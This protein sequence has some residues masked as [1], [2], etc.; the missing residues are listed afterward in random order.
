MFSIPGKIKN[1][2]LP[3]V[4]NQEAYSKLSSTITSNDKDDKN[5]QQLFSFRNPEAGNKITFGKLQVYPKSY[6]DT[7]TNDIAF[8]SLYPPAGDG[9]NIVINTLLKYIPGIQIREFLPDTK[10]DQTINLFQQL[11]KVA[12]VA[13]QNFTNSSKAAIDESK[14]QENSD[15]TQLAFNTGSGSIFDKIQKIS[16]TVIDYLT[17]EKGNMFNN[18]SSLTDFTKSNTYS[19]KYQ[20]YIFNFPYIM[21]YGLQA[22]TTMNLYELPCVTSDNIM[23]S[24]NGSPGWPSAGLSL[25][26]SLPGFISD[27][28][29]LGSFITSLLG[30]VNVSFM[31]W[32]NGLEG[33][34][35]PAPDITIKVNLF[36][37]SKEAAINNFIFVNTL[38]PNARWMQYAIFQ[39]SPCLYDIRL[40]GYKRLYAC[41]G[42]FTVTQQGVLRTPSDS[43]FDDL[44]KKHCNTNVLMV[45]KD[46]L[47]N[48]IKIPDIYNVELKFK[49][50]LPDTFNN[51]IFQY[52]KN[53]NIINE[54]SENVRQNENLSSVFTSM[55]KDVDSTLS[56]DLSIATK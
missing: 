38:I 52:I 20:N 26:K 3:F 21:W 55:F 23:Y 51:Y 39:H 14:K 8:K 40:D 24:A 36:N 15:L 42:E 56:T 18:L 37:D 11:M 2:N 25:S 33:N 16:K 49:S 47:K 32:W 9:V 1:V 4:L 6:E 19:K 29:I 10:L 34:A 50:L 13:Y 12:K 46:E 43:W 48:Y 31:P 45:N 5:L 41:T 35:T 28:P 27:I 22:C 44:E 30:N 53:N 7:I 54:Y 17:G